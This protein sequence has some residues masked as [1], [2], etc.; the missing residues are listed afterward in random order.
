MKKRKK[1]SSFSLS[2]SCFWSLSVR[3]SEDIFASSLWYFMRVFRRKSVRG[4]IQFLLFFY[5]LCSR[6]GRCINFF[7]VVFFVV[8]FVLTTT[9]KKSRVVLILLLFQR[10]KS[11]FPSLSERKRE[12]LRELNRNAIPITFCR[13]FAS[14][15]SRINS[16][17]NAFILFIFSQNPAK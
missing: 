8:F 7:F 4:I 9:M 11:V 13:R 10:A 17:T 16:L 6:Y 5:A 3:S 14:D 2:F 15:A 1:E 12:R